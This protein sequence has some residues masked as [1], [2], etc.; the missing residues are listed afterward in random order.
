MD[1]R[2][3]D[4]SGTG[5]GWVLTQ[6]GGCRAYVRQNMVMH[7]SMRI[8][9]VAGA[10]T[11]INFGALQWVTQDRSFGNNN[12]QQGSNIIGSIPTSL[13]NPFSFPAAVSSAAAEQL[14]S[15]VVFTFNNGAAVDVTFRFADPQLIRFDELE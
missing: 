8:A 14:S 5:R 3:N 9:R 11:N 15:E 2:L 1:I 6:A 10:M 13:G 4:T 12:T 7:W